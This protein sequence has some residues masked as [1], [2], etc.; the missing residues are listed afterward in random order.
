MSGMRKSPTLDDILGPNIDIVEEKR[1]NK[2]EKKHS[3]GNGSK[4]KSVNSGAN[5]KDKGGLDVYNIVKTNN[6]ENCKKLV[7]N[8]N[9]PD[10]KNIGKINNIDDILNNNLVSF[11]NKLQSS[12]FFITYKSLITIGKELLDKYNIKLPDELFYNSITNVIPGLIKEY[13]SNLKK[14]CKKVFSPDMICLGRKLDN[15]QCSRKKHNGSDFCKSHLRKLSNGRIDQP[16]IS[17]KNK[18]GRKRKVQ[19]D[20]RQYDNEY[21]TLWEDLIDG[22]KVLVDINNNVYTFDVNNPVYIGKKH[23]DLKIL[24]T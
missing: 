5:N 8:E 20:P 4:T 21:I 17:N 22:N 23:I 6:I 18:R 19:F 15:K 11:D 1:I 13:N 24:T 16:I 2:K 12:M 10:S 9:I 7:E 3:G 14:R